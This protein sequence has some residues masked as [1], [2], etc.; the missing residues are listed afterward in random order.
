MGYKIARMGE[1]QNDI[2]TNLSLRVIVEKCLRGDSN[3]EYSRC[4]KHSPRDTTSKYRRIA[5]GFISAGG[6]DSG[7]ISYWGVTYYSVKYV[8][9]ELFMLRSRDANAFSC[10]SKR[11]DSI[12]RAYLI[13]GLITIFETI[14]G[15]RYNKSDIWCRN[16]LQ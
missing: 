10:K 6:I 2:N 16:W 1:L 3:D 15:I 5:C 13:L 11:S 7:P 8:V 12:I 14:L 4:T 9:N